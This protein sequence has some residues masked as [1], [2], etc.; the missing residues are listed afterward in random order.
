MVTNFP[1]VQRLPNYVFS[2]II[3]QMK[4][5]R[6]AG[7]DIIDFGMGNP[8]G[9]P[10][11]HVVEK[12]LDAVQN[13]RSHRYSISK[14][15][16]NLRLAICKWYKRR[17]SVELDPNSEAIVCMGAKEGFSHLMLAVLDQGAGVLVPSPSYPIHSY[18]PL[19]TGGKI[20]PVKLTPEEDFLHNLETVMRKYCDTNNDAPKFVVLSFP[21][22]PTTA[23]VD[24]NFFQRAIDFARE[25][26]LFVIHDF[27]YAD[28]VFDGY[29]PPSILQIPGAKDIA[30]ELFSLSKSYNLPGWRFGFVVGNPA[31]VHALERIKSYLDYGIFLPMQI[32]AIT[33]LNGP[34]DCVSE[35]VET[36]RK[37]RDA[38]CRGLNR[39]GWQVTPPKA[40]MFVWA[41]IPEEF[42]HMGSLNFT[43]FLL[44]KAK[45]TVSPGIG[46]GEEGEGYVRFALI[47][48][49]HRTLQAIRGIKE[50]FEDK[51][52]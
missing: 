31:M 50:A 21:H 34:Q 41:R 17:Y 47:E 45:V 10:P 40:T 43:K 30:V 13:P 24:L 5:A 38:L 3:K 52:S 29:R 25:H 8:D 20:I 28:L 44:E 16:D 12:L 51:I 26:N 7:Q 23:V 6:R 39:I 15:I 9:P 11:K 37:R 19:I 4:E 18:A 1:R 35:I 22:N 32:A 49:E 48:N 27:A 14:G 42:R 46:F 2:Q 33:A 36:Y